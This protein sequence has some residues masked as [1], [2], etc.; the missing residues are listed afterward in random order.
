MESTYGPTWF[1]TNILDISFKI[2]RVS[3]RLY[4]ANVLSNFFY[5]LISTVMSRISGLY[6]LSY[7]D[8][9]ECGASKNTLILLLIY[10][11]FARA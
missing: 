3:F 10:N 6:F 4:T 9:D 5:L 11:R 8:V 1:G 7:V 2:L